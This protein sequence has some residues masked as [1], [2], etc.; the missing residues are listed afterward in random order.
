MQASLH[1]LASSSVP[2]KERSTRVSVSN[3]NNLL[4]EPEVLTDPQIQVLALTVLATLVKHST[5]GAET[6]VLYEYLAE[7]SVV[8]PK[9]FPVIH[10]LLDAK[11]NQ[12]LSNCYDKVILTCVQ[13]IIQNMIASEHENVSQQLHSIQAYGF[14][15]LWRFAGPFTKSSNTSVNAE[16]FRNCLEAMVE[17]C[18]SAGDQEPDQL[19]ACPSLLS[20]SSTVNASSSLS[21]PTVGSPTEK[22][23][24]QNPF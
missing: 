20:V 1:K 23:C 15:G 10:C 2:S 8:F 5:D 9:V 12:V 3:E 14:G 13:C 11:I 21:S 16:L 6:R 7:A 18:W 4:L 24:L 22:V 17:T 19:P